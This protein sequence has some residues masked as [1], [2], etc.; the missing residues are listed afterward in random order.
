MFEYQGFKFNPVRRFNH[1]ENYKYVMAHVHANG[2][3]LMKYTPATRGCESI[4]RTKEGD[5]DRDEFYKASNNSVCDIFECVGR[6]GLWVP[7]ENMLMRF[8]P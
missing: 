2:C 5:W 7:A 3:F 4:V 8:M 1:T 6:R